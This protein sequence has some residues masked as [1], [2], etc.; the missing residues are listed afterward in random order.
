MTGPMAT[1]GSSPQKKRGPPEEET[2][3]DAVCERPGEQTRRLYDVVA[4]SF[5]EAVRC[6]LQ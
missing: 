5:G 6:C 1:E 2:L 4:F 3:S